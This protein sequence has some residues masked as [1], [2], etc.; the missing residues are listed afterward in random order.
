MMLSKIFILFIGEIFCFPNEPSQKIVWKEVH[1]AALN[2]LR[3]GISV[4]HFPDRQPISKP[5]RLST[6]K[7]QKSNSKQSI[8]RQVFNA[9]R[10]EQIDTV[11]KTNKL[12]NM[13]RKM[14]EQE[15]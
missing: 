1:E 10:Y 12:F 14:F 9:A 11:L 3:N 2:E 15:W 13:Y 6:I 7:H 8:Y 4:F 5:Q